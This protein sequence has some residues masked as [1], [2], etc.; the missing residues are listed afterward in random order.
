MT[1]EIYKDDI[2]QYA[3]SAYNGRIEIKHNE[4]F[5]P[6]IN[7]GIRIKLEPGVKIIIK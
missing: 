4:I 1:L 6:D 7:A 5:L 2:F 3:I